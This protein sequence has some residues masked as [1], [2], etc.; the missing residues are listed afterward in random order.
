MDAE[1]LKE[2]LARLGFDIDEAGAQKFTSW[3]GTATKRVMLFGGGIQ[4]AAAG[5]YYGVYK[6]AQSN[7]ELL[8]TAEALGMSVER[9]RELNFVAEQQGGNAEA[10]KSSLEGLKGAM[11]GATIGQGGL[12]TFARLGIRIKDTTGK[13]RDTADVLD[14]IGQKIKKMDRPRAE[15]FLGQLGIDKSLYK[16]LSQDVTG[17]TS[18]YRDM[19]AATGMDAQLAAEQSREFVKEVKML[20][21]VFSLLAETVNLALIGKAGR[22]LTDFR[23]ILLANFKPITEV[24]LGLIKLIIQLAGF[25]GGLVVRLTMWLGTLVRWFQRLDSSTQTLILSVLGFAAAWKYL[26]L[27]FMAT[28]IGAII[29][30]LIVLVA[31]IDDFMT[32]LEGGESLID[33]GPWAGD[34]M[35]IAGEMGKLLDVLENLWDTVKGPLGEGLRTMFDGAIQAVSGLFGALVHMISYVSA[36]LNGDWDAAWQAAIKLAK[37]LWE[38]VQGVL[39]LTGISGA[40]GAVVDRIT[41]KDEGA[42]AL[43]PA[44]GLATAAATSGGSVQLAA[45]TVVNVDGSGDPEATGRAV[46][47]Q[48]GRV[49][50]DLV[51]NMRGAAK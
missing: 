14:D 32:Y 12:A 19:Y 39:K 17:L 28:P 43:V 27:S 48:Q 26:N 23:R 20:K 8:G 44:Q 49:N 25:F 10:V 31:L 45:N 50:A 16:M 41:G 34:I 47:G 22:D 9:L 24:L 7:A 46:A 3:L 35:S 13:L 51:R 15:M 36:L 5:L 37:D 18:A 29:T 2:F 38:I 40:I 4:A 1:V 21:T 33:W 30:G 11:A 6:I 42:P